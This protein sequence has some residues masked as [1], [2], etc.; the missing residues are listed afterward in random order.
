M[1]IK[2]QNALYVFA[3]GV[4][5]RQSLPRARVEQAPHLLDDE[6]LPH[7]AT[8]LAIRRRGLSP[9]RLTTGDWPNERCRKRRHPIA[10]AFPFHEPRYD[11]PSHR[12]Q[13]A[14][15]GFLGVTCEVI[16]TPS[17]GIDQSAPTHAVWMIR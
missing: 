14:C 16:L 12:R 8:P 13:C 11:R 2:N 9:I 15:V 1:V 3:Y 7:L 6:N 5:F 4:C 10:K 17:F